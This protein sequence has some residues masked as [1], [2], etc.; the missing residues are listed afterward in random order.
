MLIIRS[1][2]AS[3][4]RSAAKRDLLSAALVT[5]GAL[6][7]H[8]LREI[9]GQI[10]VLVCILLIVVFFAAKYKMQLDHESIAAYFR[11][12]L[13]EMLMAASGVLIL[14]GALLKIVTRLLR[15]TRS[16]AR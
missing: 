1:R 4:R 11:A 16:R 2:Q 7:L 14:I 6:M 12:H 3:V 8:S 5:L 10:L 13:H 15:S 9:V